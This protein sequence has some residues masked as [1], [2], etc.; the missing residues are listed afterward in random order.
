MI[1]DTYSHGPWEDPTHKTER[2]AVHKIPIT[3]GCNLA[4]AGQTQLSQSASRAV[5]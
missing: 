4:A 3:V 1:E 2:R 5:L